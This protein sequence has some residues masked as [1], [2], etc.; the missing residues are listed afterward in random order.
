MKKV[1][2]TGGT[3]FIGINVIDELLQ[4]G[5]EVH[6]SVFSSVL[7]PKVNLVQHKINLMDENAVDTLLKEHRFKDLIHLAWF[8][9]EKCHSADINIRWLESTLNLLQSFAK[10]GGKKFFGAGSVSEYDFNCGYLKEYVAPLA[11]SSLYGQCKSG[12]YN[13]A[14]IFCN[15][16]NIGFKWAR[17]F[18]QYGPNE[19]VTR[20]MPTVIKSALVGEDIRVSDCLKIQDYLHVFDTSKA[21]V[22]LFEG[23]VQGAVN[24]CS[25]MPVRLRTI[26]EK[27]ADLT[28]FQGDILWGA[29][30]ASFDDPFV[31]GSNERLTKEVGWKQQ[32]SLDDG[33]QMTIDWWKNNDVQ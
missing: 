18:N 33:L 12:L 21:I 17:I 26:V 8:T 27:I 11:S 3:G 7:L 13:I 32:I 14:K 25:G 22:T 5:Y 30:P 24:I 20:L 31:V 19:K 1:L 2:V 6:T 4:M 9:G 23:T 29:I 10:Y 16:H 15:S 28:D